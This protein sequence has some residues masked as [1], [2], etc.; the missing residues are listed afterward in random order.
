VRDV[1]RAMV[2]RRRAPSLAFCRVLGCCLQVAV[3]QVASDAAAIDAVLP[4]VE[5][6]RG[7]R[8]RQRHRS[9]AAPIWALFQAY[10][11]W[12]HDAPMVNGIMVDRASG[13]P[14]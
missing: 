7:R 9:T 11:R 8:A 14:R 2:V 10:D 12:A 6:R 13:V 3:R 4:A 1:S 5:A